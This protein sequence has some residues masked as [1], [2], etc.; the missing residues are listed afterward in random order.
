M[1]ELRELENA[2]AHSGASRAKAFWRLGW[3]SFWAQIGFGSLTVILA[4]YALI[5]GQNSGAGTRAGNLLIEYLT[6]AN[7]V[8]LV[9][10]TMRSYRYTR[11]AHQLADPERQPSQLVVHR[12]AWIGVAAGATGI[13]F[14]ML[15]VL[16]EVTQFLFIFFVPLK[17]ECPRFRPRAPGQQAG[18]LQPT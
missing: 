13:V 8:V 16:F 17:R 14:S 5:F 6:V 18:C 3:I 2:W 15:V 12:T 7:L 10:T 9:F 11:L 4:V 1:V